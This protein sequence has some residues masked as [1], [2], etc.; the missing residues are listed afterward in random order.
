MV[1]LEG[2]KMDS[3]VTFTKQLL[4]EESVFCLP[5]MVSHAV[6]YAFNVCHAQ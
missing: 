4:V 6:W 1:D 5:G 3:D 2:F